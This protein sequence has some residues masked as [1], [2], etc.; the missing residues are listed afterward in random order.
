MTLALLAAPAA[1]RAGG[2]LEVSLGSGLRA[3]LGST[4][5]IPTNAMVALGYGFTSML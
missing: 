4:E 3:G 2:L 1:S 5:R